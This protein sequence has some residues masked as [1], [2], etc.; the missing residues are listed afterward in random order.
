MPTPALDSRDAAGVVPLGAPGVY[1]VPERPVRPPLGVPMDECAFVGVAPRGPAFEVVEGDDG[2]E[3]TQAVVVP[4]R[5]WDDYRRVFGAFEGPGLLPLSVSAFFEQGGRVAHVVRVVPRATGLLPLARAALEFD[6][7]V[8]TAGTPLALFARNEGA[9]GSRLSAR[10][11]YATTTLPLSAT[12]VAGRELLLGAAPLA[13][14]AVLRL[15]TDD[16]AQRTR[17]VEFS[18][19]RPTA[20]GPVWV[21]M[22]DDGVP[23]NLTAIELVE[24]VLD[25]ADGDP[26]MARAER[27]DHLGLMPAHPRWLGDVVWAQSLLVEPDIAPGEGVAPDAALTASGTTVTTEGVD[28]Y[29]EIDGFDVMEAG[30]PAALAAPDPALLC[31]PDLYSPAPLPDDTDV[32][33]PDT[34]AGP[35]FAECHPLRPRPARPAPPP[36][37]DGLRLDPADADDLRAITARQS[38]LVHLAEGARVVALLDVPPGLRTAAVEHWRRAFDSSYAAAY[39]PWLLVPRDGVHGLGRLVALPP[40]SAAAGVIARCELRDGLPHGPANEVVANVP[41]A[42]VRVVEPDHGVLHWSGVNVFAMEPAGVTLTGARTISNERA[43]RQ[44]SARRVVTMIER[45]VARQMQWVVFEP[46]DD[47][48]RTVVRTAVEHLLADLFRA[49]A[50]RGATPAQSYFVRTSTGRAQAAE[51]DAGWLLC[52]IGVAPS[53]P[54]EFL[55]VRVYRDGDGTIRAE[56]LRA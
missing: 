42:V 22:L 21:G 9:W 52:E 20:D 6:T 7:A 55:L 38:D 19:K 36:G 43:W 54:M 50:F 51:Q 10:L 13:G 31:V 34:L 29:P 30:V 49:G 28:R 5:S 35:T 53:E 3:R 45:A 27:F 25:V 47:R 11:S 4:V 26:A 23:G 18:I 41:D 16:G 46:N 15:T 1:V 44:L 32:Q 2:P 39:H 8:T 17:V 24:G 33:P 40:S 14:G 56:S 12:A 37:L 48:T